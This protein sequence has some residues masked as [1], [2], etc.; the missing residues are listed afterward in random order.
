MNANWLLLGDFNFIRSLDNRD[1]PGGNVNDIFLFNE[2]IGHLGLLELSL[3]GRSYTWSNMK[4]QPLLEQLDW[5]FTTSSWISLYP[6]TVVH[7]LV[8]IPCLVSIDT[9]IPRAKIFRFENYWVDLPGFMDCVTASWNAP[10]A[11]SGSAAAVISKKFKRLR[12]DLKRWHINL[13]SIKKVILNCSKVILCLDSLEECVPLTIPE[14]NFRK[15]VKL[16][17]EDLLRL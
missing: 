1:L 15:I 11:C 13:A 5:F 2:I 16:H 12:S 14:F 7:P 9:T 6:N 3:K 17:H 10:L 4:Q 8:H